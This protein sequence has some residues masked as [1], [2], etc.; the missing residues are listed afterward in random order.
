MNI[1]I[2]GFIKSSIYCG[3][4]V[5][6]FEQFNAEYIFLEVKLYPVL[7]RVQLL[8]RQEQHFQGNE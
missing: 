1:Y 7:K 5:I 3:N 8:P 4:S 6:Q 2:T